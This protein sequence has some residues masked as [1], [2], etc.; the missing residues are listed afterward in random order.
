[1]PAAEPEQAGMSE[2]SRLSG[3]F[4]EPKKA[5]ADIALHPRWVVPIALLI[6]AGMAF[7]AAVAN[8]IGWERVV[9]QQIEQRAATMSI[10]QREAVER[11]M[12]V[13]VRIAS[14]GAYAAIVFTPV[15]M[16]VVAGVLL[17]IANGLMSADLK[18][19]QVYAIVCYSMIP[20]AIYSLLAI[21]VIYLKQPDDF[22]I[23]NPLAFNP[24]AFM[25]PQTSGKFLHSLATSLDLFTIWTILLI[26][27]GLKVAAGRRISSSG[28]LMA[29][30][31]PWGI[32]VL[33]AAAL[34]AAFGG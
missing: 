2:A 14:A 23:R 12:G 28:A 19:K 21:L 8:R 10:Q 18:L 27:A 22:D 24:G 34:A 26:A 32:L 33:G 3:I 5:F 17:G 7:S 9:R 31:L 20:R 15:V 11:S 4:F 29:V 25:D 6:L 13:S 16:L 1:M 30:L